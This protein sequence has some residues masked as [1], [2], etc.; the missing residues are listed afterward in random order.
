MASLNKNNVNGTD[1][2]N[3]HADERET[4]LEHDSEPD[5]DMIFSRSSISDDDD[6]KVHRNIDSVKIQIREVTDVIRDNVQ[7]V[8]E[9]GERLEDLQLASDR[10][11]FAGNEFFDAAKRAQRRAWIQNIKSRVIIIG[12]TV[13]AI[14]CI[15]VLD[16]VVLYL[17][18]K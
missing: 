2:R 5:E 4:L 16:V 18:L 15:I 7:K 13:V 1:F 8:L 3:A 17:V 11:S 10:L 9:R 6:I 14:I 12:I